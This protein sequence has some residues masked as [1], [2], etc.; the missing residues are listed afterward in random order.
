[1][2]KPP[3]HHFCRQRP[4]GLRKETE[5]CLMIYWKDDQSDQQLKHVSLAKPSSLPKDIGIQPYPDDPIAKLHEVLICN[6]KA[7]LCKI[8]ELAELP[9][10]GMI[11]VC[12]LI[13]LTRTAS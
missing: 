6:M 12:I 4:R 3:H 7:E 2:F 11:H 8:S 10:P 1:M 5:R 13:F 9:I